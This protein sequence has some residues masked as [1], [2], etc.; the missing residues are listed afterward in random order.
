[1]SKTHFVLYILFCGLFLSPVSRLHIAPALADAEITEHMMTRT[2]QWNSGCSLPIPTD[3]FDYTDK[4]ANCWFF[5]INA[6]TTD[7]I[8]CQWYKPDGTL[9]TEHKTLTFYPS[10]CWYCRI[11]INGHAPEKLPGEWQVKVHVGD[12]LHFTEHF[13]LVGEPSADECPVELI[14]GQDSAETKLLRHLRD[15]LLY[16]SAEGRELVSLYYRYSPVIARTLRKD[17]ALKQEVK[18]IA[19]AV[20]TL[21]N[22]ADRGEDAR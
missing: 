22:P 1:M 7:E 6:A 12:A 8:I 3:I 11:L 19:D 15:M 18:I 13:T 2:P 10:G 9:Y 4:E 14:Y 5:W 20:L 16:K 21:L 17:A